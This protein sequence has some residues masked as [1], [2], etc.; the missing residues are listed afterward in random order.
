MK[1]SERMQEY[2]TWDFSGREDVDLPLS[3]RIANTYDHLG[4]IGANWHPGEV[5]QLEEENKK[6]V[7]YSNELEKRIGEHIEKIDKGN[8]AIRKLEE[9]NK[10]LWEYF[11]AH[12]AV[13]IG[14]AS[15]DLHN[16]AVDRLTKARDTLAD[17]Q[18]EFCPACDA[19]A[20]HC[21]G[22]HKS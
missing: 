16:E 10:K 15:M 1:P 22:P 5:A 14:L 9:E 11:N 17:T 20:G 7:S 19:G 6:I 18:D 13:E 2:N 4:I 3:E 21:I 8:K 12:V